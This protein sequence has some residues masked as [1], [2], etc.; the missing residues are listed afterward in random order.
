MQKINGKWFRQDAA[1]Q[2]F[3]W[4]NEG[5]LL[6]CWGWLETASPDR[7]VEYTDDS[8]MRTQRLFTPNR[9]G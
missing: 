7:V 4:T 8:W 3:V 1:G 5:T 9:R 6:N 2:W